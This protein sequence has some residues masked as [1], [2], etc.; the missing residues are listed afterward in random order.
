MTNAQLAAFR[1]LAAQMQ[2]A[3]TD[4]EWIGPHLSQRMYGITESRA[5]AYAAR[6]GGIAAKIRHTCSEDAR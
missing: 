6:F 3:P 1:E 5:K 2:L 4:W